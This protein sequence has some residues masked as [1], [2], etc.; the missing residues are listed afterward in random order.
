VRWFR[1]PAGDPLPVA[2]AGLK[3]GNRLLMLG[4]S[5]TALAALSSCSLVSSSHSAM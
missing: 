2:L 3:L 4:A 1:K 5:D